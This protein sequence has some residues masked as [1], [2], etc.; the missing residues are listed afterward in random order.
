MGSEGRERHLNECGRG[1]L[2]IMLA[3]SLGGVGRDV[4]GRRNY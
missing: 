4:V 3:G 1:V 2:K